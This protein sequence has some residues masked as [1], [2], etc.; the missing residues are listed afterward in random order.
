[1]VQTC[2]GIQRGSVRSHVSTDATIWV[3]RGGM[4][5]SMCRGCGGSLPGAFLDLGHTPLA[6][7]YVHP[8]RAVETERTYPLAVAYCPSCHL[9][10][11]N[12]TVAPEDLF[13]EYLYFSS[14][15]DSFVTHARTL[16]EELSV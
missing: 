8:E 7:A 15:S 1:M 14:Y 11:L 16:A 9:V 2:I 4:R 5:E 6:N 10:Q 12:E 13:S 3:L